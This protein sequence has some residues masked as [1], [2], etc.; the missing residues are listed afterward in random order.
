MN[1]GS[2]EA[3]IVSDSREQNSYRQVGN[4]FWSVR[5]VLGMKTVLVRATILFVIIWA[6]IDVTENIFAS[7]FRTEVCSV[8]NQ[9]ILYKEVQ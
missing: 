6:E 3:V 5:T 8:R 4:R 7:I 9:D 1:V 2:P